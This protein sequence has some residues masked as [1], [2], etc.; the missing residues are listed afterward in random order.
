MII[1]I[2]P[3]HLLFFVLHNVESSFS[4][5]QYVF[6]S[7]IENCTG[8]LGGISRLGIIGKLGQIWELCFLTIEKEFSDLEINF[9][10][11][12]ENEEKLFHKNPPLGNLCE[13]PCCLLWAPCCPS[14]APCCPP[15]V[16]HCPSCAPCCP[17]NIQMSSEI[18]LW[19]V[20][21]CM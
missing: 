13:K 20:G 16:P 14:W 15:Q 3:S 6:Y 17:S 18:H 8:K 12:G 11:L 7:C 1:C 9:S 2:L 4:M 10:G 5:I 21:T 19:T